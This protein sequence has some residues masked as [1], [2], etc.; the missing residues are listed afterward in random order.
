MGSNAH[1][2]SHLRGLWDATNQGQDGGRNERALAATGSF[3]TPVIVL[4]VAIGYY[5]GT[6][7]GFLFTPPQTPTAA[8][9]PP[10]RNPACRVPYNSS[11]EVVGSSVGG[12]SCPS[13]CSA[14]RRYSCLVDAGVVC[15]EYR[16]GIT[17]RCLHPL[18]RER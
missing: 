3:R 12:A 5:A 14:T 2:F 10:Q 8:F 16:R 9:W 13:P 7:I 6:R 1:H 15:R 18:L 4:L 17:R 11:S